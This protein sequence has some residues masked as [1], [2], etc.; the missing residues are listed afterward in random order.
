[1]FSVAD[2]I[3]QL[4]GDLYLAGWQ[5]EGKTP[6]FQLGPIEVEFA[7]VL[8]SSR[9]AGGGAKLWV[10]DASVEG[11]YSKQVTHRIRLVLNPTDADGRPTEVAGEYGDD[12]EVP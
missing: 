6:R 11:R 9:T 8:D 2:V 3:S 10:V 7:V 1:M 12:E 4:R 5:G